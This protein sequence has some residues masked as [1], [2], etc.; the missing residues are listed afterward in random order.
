MPK[1]CVIPGDGIGPEVVSE[2][3][4]VLDVVESIFAPR[5]ELETLPYGADYYLETG[6]TLPPGELERI[7]TGCDAIFLGA[8]GDPRVPGSEHARD[9]LIGLRLHLDLYVNERPARLLDARLT[10]LKG[11]QPAHPVAT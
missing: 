3:L 6:E 5:L 9:I 1:V 8:L 10:P 2:A 4:K 11:K 7:G